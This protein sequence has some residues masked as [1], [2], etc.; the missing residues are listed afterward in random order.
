[1]PLVRCDHPTPGA[2]TF[3]RNTAA[4][5]TSLAPA[6]QSADCESVPTGVFAAILLAIASEP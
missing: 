1:M 4:I 3:F 6:L 5:R 2:E